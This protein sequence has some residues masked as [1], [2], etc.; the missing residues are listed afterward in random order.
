M[1]QLILCR[2]LP[3][4]NPLYIEELDMNLY[5][6]EE[7]SY[8]IFNNL[9]LI[10]GED[11]VNEKLFRFIAEELGRP[12][13]ASKLRRWSK[14]SSQGELLLVILQDLHYYRSEEL[15]GFQERVAH[16]ANAS[17]QERLRQKADNLFAKHRYYEAVLLYDRLLPEM[18]VEAKDRE[19]SGRLWFNRGSALC[20]LFS[21]EQAMQSYVEAYQLLGSDEVLKKIY[22]VGRLDERVKVPSELLNRVPELTLEEWKGEYDG[23]L[24]QIGY[25][26]SALEAASLKD[27]DKHRRA[28]GLRDL[29]LGWKKEYRRG[30]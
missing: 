16:V 17:A 10:M 15:T 2:E 13:L 27:K 25:E 21:F 6:A 30:L 22:M 5:T 20:G 19:L 3:A 28:S 1:G 8:Y 14:N 9:E 11:F 23:I 7:L 12:V 18:G 24:S 26:G 4:A 29:V